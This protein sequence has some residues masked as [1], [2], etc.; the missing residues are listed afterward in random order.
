MKIHLKI[1][2][3]TKQTFLTHI[4]LLL[5]SFAY[6]IMIKFLKELST[7]GIGNSS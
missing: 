6:L 4:I 2:T 3:E 1:K 7:L 5:S